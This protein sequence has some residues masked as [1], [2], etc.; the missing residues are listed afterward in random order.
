M[1]IVSMRERLQTAQASVAA[2][3]MRVKRQA[4]MPALPETEGRTNSDGWF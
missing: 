1:T 3:A 2:L 4:G